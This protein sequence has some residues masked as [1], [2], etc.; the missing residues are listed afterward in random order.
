MHPCI[1]PFIYPTIRSST[2]PSIHQSPIHLPIHPSIPP[3]I[4]LF[5]H[6]SLHSIVI[7]CLATQNPAVNTRHV[8]LP[9]PDDVLRGHSKWS[10]EHLSLQ[11]F[12][13]H[14]LNQFVNKTWQVSLKGN[15]W[16]RYRVIEFQKVHSNFCNSIILWTWELTQ[17]CSMI[18]SRE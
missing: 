14:S 7:P 11:S 5:I 16:G 8:A 13:Y 1:C 10:C 12:F 6:P 15:A 17:S 2:Y 18:W 3:S 4:H 9:S